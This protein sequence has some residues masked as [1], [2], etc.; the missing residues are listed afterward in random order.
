MH[1]IH[2]E[3]ILDGALRLAWWPIDPRSGG[4][5]AVS[6]EGLHASSVEVQYVKKKITETLELVMIEVYVSEQGLRPLLVAFNSW[7]VGSRS[8]CAMAG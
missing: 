1:T 2:S 4:R 8:R 5:T 6:G 7:L 3:F